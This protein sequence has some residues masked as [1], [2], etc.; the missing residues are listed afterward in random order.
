[1]AYSYRQPEIVEALQGMQVL[2]IF[3]QDLFR[4]DLVLYA[5][6]LEHHLVGSQRPGFIGQYVIHHSQF[7][8]D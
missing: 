4:V 7:L 2:Y 3:L 6:G 8:H 1:M 5:T